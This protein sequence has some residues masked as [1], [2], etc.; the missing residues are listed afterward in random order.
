MDIALAP[1]IEV[2]VWWAAHHVWNARSIAQGG[3]NKTNL[4]LMRDG[5][6]EIS[7][8][9]AVWKLTPGTA[10][11]ITPAHRRRWFQSTNWTDSYS[12]GFSAQL[13]G[14]LDLF[15]ALEE[16]VLWRPEDE[17]NPSLEELIAPL[18]KVC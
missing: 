2:E 8:D 16:P 15:Q 6:A 5:E 3:P 13:F 18:V 14:Q 1:H 12:I 17:D 4:W 9:N 11:L 10:L 7:T